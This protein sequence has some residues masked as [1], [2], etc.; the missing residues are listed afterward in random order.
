MRERLDED[1]GL[2]VFSKGG[3]KGKLARRIFGVG[4]VC[5]QKKRSSRSRFAYAQAS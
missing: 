1:D 3:K 5:V 4:Y 2:T